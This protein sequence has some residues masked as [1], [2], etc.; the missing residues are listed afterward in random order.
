MALTQ[1]QKKQLLDL[2][3]KGLSKEQAMVRVFRSAPTSSMQ[4]DGLIQDVTAAATGLGRDFMQRGDAVRESF[5]AGARGEQTAAETAFQ[6][7]GN[8][9]GGVGDITFRGAQAAV[10]PFMSGRQEQ[11]VADTAQNLFAPVGEAIGK[12]S[13]RTQR[14]IMGGLGLLEAIPGAK[15][16]TQPISALRKGGVRGLLSGAGQAA[17]PGAPT[18]TKYNKTP[19]QIFDDVGKQFKQISQDPNLSPRAQQEAAEAAMNWRERYIGLTPDV[20]SRLAKMGE[21]KITEYIDAA[22]RRN[23]DDTAPTPYEVGAQNVNTAL[24]QLDQTLRTTG[25]EIGQARAK[26]ATVKAP[27]TSVNRVENAFTSELDKLNLTIKNGQIVQKPGTVSKT[28]S[29]SDVRVL[30]SL[31]DNLQ[32]FKQ[33]PTLKNAIDL[34]MAFDGKIKFEKA[35]RDVSDSVDPLSRTVRK[36]LAE[37]AAKVVGKSN[38]AELQRYS[39]FMEAYSDLKSFTDRAAGGEYLLRLVLSGRGGEAR[40]LIDTVREY[41]G[42]DLM[43]DATAMKVATQM[44]S[45]ENAQN[46]FKQE[47]TRAGYD[48]AAVLS[49]SP[50]GILQVV[51]KRLLDYGIDPE[52]VIKA[53]AAGTGG[54]VLSVYVDEEGMVLP[55]GLAVLSAMPP[56]QRMEAIQQA[57]SL[58]K[59]VT[60]PD[61][62]KDQIGKALN[63]YDTD[64]VRMRQAGKETLEMGDNVDDD[65]FLLKRKNESGQLTNDEY[66][67]AYDALIRK[68]VAP[69]GDTSFNQGATPSTNLIEEAKKYDSAGD[70][71]NGLTPTQRDEIRRQYAGT[72]LRQAEMFEDFFAKSTGVSKKD[73]VDIG[74]AGLKKA[75]AEL[76]KKTANQYRTFDEFFGA[77]RGSATQYGEYNPR[78]RKFVLPET[79]RV[80]EIEGVDPNATITVYRGID[81][82][83]GKVKRKINK[84]DFVTT[85]FNDALSYTG[86]PSDVVRMYGKVKHLL[87]EYP[88]EFDVDTMTSYELIYNPT[89][90]YIKITDEQ[91]QEVWNAR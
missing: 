84:G 49:G 38:A 13:E 9:L 65:L 19:E 26:L 6:T 56:A 79:K 62:I 59:K 60:V 5:R 30:Q 71:Y 14:N 77:M 40:K 25:S 27:I 43:D 21:E 51:G 10:T 47:V 76:L 89:N 61:N 75:D 50:T 91:L 3:N 54:Y 52:T 41:T 48:A 64:P 2:K 53:A 17:T 63:D 87:S 73:I 1:E 78:L 4:N 33:S 29:T 69:V 72:N 81:D 55:A 39:D 74:I 86:S 66:I 68:G 67:D 85:D 31:Y 18:I 37:E 24:E 88:D 80:S 58:G 23:I 35:A 11:A 46:L 34:R 70:F 16:L 36:A 83:E 20:K 7:V 57:R 12:T 44:F 28:G 42:K 90:D 15:F 32:I 8:F 82:V 45:N 22:Y